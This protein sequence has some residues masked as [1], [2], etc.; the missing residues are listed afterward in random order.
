MLM[1]D[2]GGMIYR[3]LAKLVDPGLQRGDIHVLDLIFDRFV[4]HI[5]EGGSINASPK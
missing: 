4:G 2:D 5:V 3:V 1:S